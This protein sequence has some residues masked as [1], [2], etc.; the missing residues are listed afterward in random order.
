[1]TTWDATTLE[2]IGVI[3]PEGAAKL[4]GA[5]ITRDG[6]TLATIAEDRSVT[7]WS[8]AL[9]SAFATLRPPSPVVARML[10]G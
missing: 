9:N 1:M 5:G 4:L 3:R 2:Q 7:L 10:R 6:K 8:L